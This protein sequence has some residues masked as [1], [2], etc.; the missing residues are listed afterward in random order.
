[1]NNKVFTFRKTRR[2]TCAWVSTG[3]AKT[4]LAC[5][6]MEAEAPGAASTPSLSEDEAGGMRLCA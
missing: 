2:M 4:P 1:M 3:D 5:V 6:W